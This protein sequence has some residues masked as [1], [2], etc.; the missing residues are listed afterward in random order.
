M[1][2][3][4]GG[5]DRIPAHRSERNNLRRPRRTSQRGRRTPLQEGLERQQ[6]K[7]RGSIARPSP[8][9]H[10]E[11]AS[12]C[13]DDGIPG[14]ELGHLGASRPTTSGPRPFPQTVRCPFSVSRLTVQQTVRAGLEIGRAVS[15]ERL[16]HCGVSDGRFTVSFKRVGVPRA[17]LLRALCCQSDSLGSCLLLLLPAEEGRS[18]VGWPPPPLRSEGRVPRRS[19]APHL[20][21]PS[22]P[23]EPC[24]NRRRLLT[25]SRC[26]QRRKMDGNANGRDK[27]TWVCYQAPTPCCAIGSA[28]RSH[29]LAHPQ[30][31]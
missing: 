2:R 17:G 12:A 4:T 5:N 15:P 28:R 20:F 10:Q 19:R 13:S 16:S 18:V 30:T 6:P 7:R 22:P 31:S 3:R 23:S 26:R 29:P 8:P 27:K 11:Q 9:R 25:S 14:L 21:P 1:A 24:A